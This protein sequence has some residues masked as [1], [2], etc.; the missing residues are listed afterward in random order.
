VRVAIA[1]IKREDCKF[2][3]HPEFNERDGPKEPMV[4]Y[5]HGEY[6]MRPIQLHHLARM[7]MIQIHNDDVTMTVGTVTVI[8]EIKRFWRSWTSPLGS[9]QY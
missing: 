3:T 9:H 8:E 1:I 5:C 4:P 6:Q 7:Q 2:R